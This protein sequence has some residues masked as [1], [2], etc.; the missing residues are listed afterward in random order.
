MQSDT[1]IQLS[2][3]DKFC[4][5]DV[6]KE[7][8][9]LLNEVDRV[10][11]ANIQFHDSKSPSATKFCR[12]NRKG[13]PDDNGDRWMWVRFVT[14]TARSCMTDRDQEWW[15]K[16]VLVST[17]AMNR[18][19]MKSAERCRLIG[20]T[21]AAE[22]FDQKAVKD[23]GINLALTLGFHPA[24]IGQIPEPVGRIVLPEGWEIH[25]LQIYNICLYNDSNGGTGQGCRHVVLS[26][27]M[28][29][30]SMLS[31]PFWKKLVKTKGPLR[32]VMVIEHR[33]LDLVIDYVKDHVDAFRGVLFILVSPLQ[34]L[35]RRER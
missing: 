20:Y 6:I 35:C 21:L 26:G 32:A 29:V 8:H 31:R 17:E 16:M 5:T 27:T 2:W 25:C 28:D 18:L 24:T 10:G 14:V 22:G 12:T 11:R 34:V 3:K 30:P 13:F 23:F 19:C 15:G 4:P 9:S 7:I 33:N 1:P